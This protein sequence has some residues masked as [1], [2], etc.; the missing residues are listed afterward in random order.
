MPDLCQK[1]PK[2]L[3]NDA[4]HEWSR[5]IIRITSFQSTFSAASCVICKHGCTVS[6]K[7]VKIYKSKQYLPDLP[8]KL[9]NSPTVLAGSAAGNTRAEQWCGGASD[10]SDFLLH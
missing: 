4:K 2:Y 6:R 7:A 10:Q 3:V 1:F 5:E 8:D 9:A